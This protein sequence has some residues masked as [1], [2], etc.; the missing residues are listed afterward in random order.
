MNSYSSTESLTQGGRAPTKRPATIVIG[1]IREQ[2]QPPPPCDRLF[3]RGRCCVPWPYAERACDSAAP[4]HST[5]SCSGPCACSSV[6][7]THDVLCSWAR[8]GR[9]IAGGG[10]DA[11]Q[12]ALSQRHVAREG[13]LPCVQPCPRD[14]QCKPN[15]RRKVPVEP[16]TNHC[17]VGGGVPMKHP[18]PRPSTALRGATDVNSTAAGRG[19]RRIIWNA[20]DHDGRC[21]YLSVANRCP[22]ARRRRRANP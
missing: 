11:D 17:A 1:T 3:A 22:P 9:R 4:I 19:F 13:F 15:E 5:R 14:A 18:P 6:Q 2:C 21:V 8:A 20:P 16:R 10:G 7:L 12:N